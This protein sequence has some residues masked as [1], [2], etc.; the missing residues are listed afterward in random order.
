ML[1]NN[2]AYFELLPQFVCTNS[3]GSTFECER[4]EFCSGKYEVAVDWTDPKSLINWASQDSL[5]L[6]CVPKEKIGLMGTM[7]FFGWMVGAIFIPRLSDVYGRK[8]PF[9]ILLCM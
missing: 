8:K 3:D 6:N 7:V 2:L 9:M 1:A 4:E 5:N